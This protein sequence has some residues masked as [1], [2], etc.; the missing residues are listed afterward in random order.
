[1]RIPCLVMR[2]KAAR[3]SDDTLAAVSVASLS[4]GYKL[5]RTACPACLSGLA[6]S[7]PWLCVACAERCM[8]VLAEGSSGKW[9]RLTT[10]THTC[11]PRQYRSTIKV[12]KEMSMFLQ[13]FLPTVDP[14]SARTNSTSSPKKAFNLL[15]RAALKRVRGPG[16]CVICKQNPRRDNIIH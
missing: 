8:R 6:L 7:W 5:R 2:G 16:S 1:M 12:P 15:P 3:S 4:G 13:E 11:T 14:S 10:T 9:S